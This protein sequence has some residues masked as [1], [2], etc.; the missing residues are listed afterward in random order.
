MKGNGT[1]Q[2]GTFVPVPFLGQKRGKREQN[3]THT[4]RCVPLFPSD[5]G[6]VRV[7]G[8][9]VWLVELTIQPTHPSASSPGRSW[10]RWQTAVNGWKSAINF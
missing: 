5:A 6:N 4:F 9:M 2:K 3:G 7:V 10:Q 8:L 1:E